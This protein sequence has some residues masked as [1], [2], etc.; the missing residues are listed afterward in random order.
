M[1][2]GDM[3]GGGVDDG[4]CCDKCGAPITTG[5]MAVFCPRAKDCEFWP[6]DEAGEIFIMQLRASGDSNDQ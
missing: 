2:P 6:T 1:H 3:V 4:P 5:M